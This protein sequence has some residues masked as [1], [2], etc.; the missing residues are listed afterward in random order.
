MG[1]VTSSL[2]IRLQDDVSARAAKAAGALKQL[3]DS[4]KNLSRLGGSTAGL[5]KVAQRLDALR[6]KLEA[7]SRFK[8]AGRGLIDLGVDLRKARADLA[9][10]DALLKK[11]QD[12]LDHFARVKKTDPRRYATWKA[13]GLVDQVAA[14]FT[15][16]KAAQAQAA[17]AAARAQRAY[18]GQRATVQEMRAKLLPNG[19]PAARLTGTEARLRA[20]IAQTEGEQRAQAAAQAAARARTA[21][22][23]IEPG[24]RTAA[25]IDALMPRPGGQS[26]TA[27][28]VS[29][30]PAT[31]DGVGR[32]AGTA[33]SAAAGLGKVETK[34]RGADAAVR[35]LAAA[36]PP[37]AGFSDALTRDLAALDLTKAET[38]ALA[39]EVTRMRA[40]Q[41]K[42]LG[43]INPRYHAQILDAD[44]GQI[45]DRVRARAREMAEERR[46]ATLLRP[47]PKADAKPADEV[48]FDPAAVRGMRERMGLAARME[49]QR[50]SETA[51][52]A[53]SD[54][55][56]FR[57]RFTFASR[58]ARQRAQEER[59]AGSEAAQAAREAARETAR[60]E[61]QAARETA[62][63]AREAAREKIQAAREAARE[64]RRL[65]RDGSRETAQ[66][67]REAARVAREA[68]RERVAAAREAARAAQE[69]ARQE[70][71]ALRAVARE[72]ARAA[73]EAARQDREGARARREVGHHARTAAGFVGA[74]GAL[75]GTERLART[76]A[77]TAG[78][79]EMETARGRAVGLTPEE[80]KIGL[81]RANALS[82]QF[83]SL[84]P[85]ELR[86][87]YRALH[88]NL[89]GNAKAASDTLEPVARSQVMLQNFRTR[90][91]A[92]SDL[93][94]IIRGA[95]NM[96]I[97][98]D[99]KKFEVYL[100]GATKG[101]QLFGD[102]LRG[103]DYYQY[104]K[105]GRLAVAG[106]NPRFLGAIA[107]SII[108]DMGGPS[109]GQAHYTA[110]NAV[111][112]GR[113]KKESKAAAKSFGL[114]GKDGR[115]IGRDT[116]QQD[117]FEWALKVLEPALARKGKGFDPN[118]SGKFVDTLTTIFND[119][120]AAEFI[121]KL[122]TKQGELK[123]NEE[124]FTKVRGLE[125]AEKVR[126]ENPA[127]ALEGAKTQGAQ[128]LG[129]ALAPAI[130][131]AT[132]ALNGLAD[133]A[134]SASAKLRENPQ[135]VEG[136][137]VVASI[138]GAV[139][140]PKVA[141]AL[142]TKLAGDGTGIVANALRMG[143]A[144]SS[145]AGSALGYAGGV[146]VP[147][148]IGAAA[149]E[150][151][152]V[153]EQALPN[154]LAGR[155]SPT[156]RIARE[157]G[158]ARRQQATETGQRDELDRRIG[159]MRGI[160][161]RLTTHYG[162]AP[163]GRVGQA[164]AG[165]RKVLG[166]LEGQRDAI[167]ERLREAARGRA[168]GQ[169]VPIAAPV[170]PQAPVAATAPQAAVAA[171]APVAATA[172]TAAQSPVDGAAI[173][174]A[175]AELARY[176][177]ELAIVSERQA[178]TAALSL[179]GLGR[180]LTAKRAEIEGLISGLEARIKALGSE[181][182][183]PNIDASQVE[184]LGQ[185]SGEAHDKLTS[186]NMTVA[187]QVD[188]SSLSAAIALARSFNAELAKI[189]PAIAS[190]RAQAASLTVPSAGQGGGGDGVGRQ[191]S[192][193]MVR[194]GLANNFA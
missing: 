103:E 58:M 82:K 106:L 114:M 5:D 80:D 9:E 107:P 38:R 109:A 84:N 120:N 77:R 41:V 174:Q 155:E 102:T 104:A 178:A 119:R 110:S 52:A 159:G 29:L 176:R 35:H 55:Q 46:T 27:A 169:E 189:G 39:R 24:R 65:E 187:P 171:R 74:G 51:A 158:E 71:T 166:E 87:L 34:A 25:E 69:S 191:A 4:G 150:A 21:Q 54:G 179:P 149:G 10:A 67:A 70:A 66:A 33:A 115:M 140:G 151:G 128:L 22:S 16:A 148:A 125:D 156:A 111:V 88:V 145:A 26:S 133:A 130:N 164:L 173:A 129:E 181:T 126:R 137:G 14:N 15:A 31:P 131:P 182:I 61:A 94:R 18:D 162:E 64:A 8:A 146:G 44:R 60:V 185:K 11:R 23:L 75:Y 167:N 105:T 157:L 43:P 45:E 7:V 93:A 6:G 127:V 124:R 122:V 50:A 188:T 141:G 72:R 113:M 42:A 3:G 73:R 17:R 117:P 101:M 81:D 144:A 116:F 112:A 180:D 68:A 108:D 147:A 132:V 154:L 99:P 98:D 96:G 20:L 193:G 97:S 56:A 183:A 168:L 163:A 136:G 138:L 40:D 49:R 62:R 139:L 152:A 160:I 90:D 92:Q 47:A 63:V 142:M 91:E 123:R 95:E 1:T 135:A 37:L 79:S 48:T 89:G 19:G 53:A 134:A 36:P 59:R 121:G 78:Q 184:G 28:P 161:D 192:T 76:G 12:T 85:T 100:Q 172:P 118:D 186:L 175:A 165:H 2:V 153:N 57:E 86:E 32:A 30:A 190:A 83:P 177:A 143:G 194:R 170:A 13:D